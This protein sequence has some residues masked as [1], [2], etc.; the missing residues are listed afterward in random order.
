MS[1]HT[2]G[3]WEICGDGKCPCK[4]V[5]SE[6][7]PVA[8]VVAGEWGDEYEDIKLEKREGYIGH[9]AIAYI[10]KIIY[11]EVDEETARAN[12]RLIA[13]APDLLAACI[14]NGMAAD[15][16]R[17]SGPD[18]LEDAANI[19]NSMHP[20]LALNLL[21]KARREREAIAKAK[22]ERE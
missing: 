1:E 21:N 2:P 6:H 15:E 18:M 7:H 4:Q 17:Y 8:E 12:A 3:P 10:E 9:R 16:A 11:G 13:A 5:W 14:S 20:D 22:G 19:L